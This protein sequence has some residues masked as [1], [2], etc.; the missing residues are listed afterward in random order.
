MSISIT[1]QITCTCHLFKGNIAISGSFEEVSELIKLEDDLP[2][3]NDILD[4][5]NDDH[6]EA[7]GSR[8]DF[9]VNCIN[10]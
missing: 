5:E 10:I 7:A 4:A 6:T 3:I 8:D 9:K 2:Q 1:F